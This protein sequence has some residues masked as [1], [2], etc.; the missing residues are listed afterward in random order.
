MHEFLDLQYVGPVDVMRGKIE[1]SE[2][3]G[4][5]RDQDTWLKISDLKNSSQ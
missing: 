5:H 4:S 1:E 2:K 3:A